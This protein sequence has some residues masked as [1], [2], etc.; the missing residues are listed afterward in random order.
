MNSM[1]LL[2]AGEHVLFLQGLA[3]LLQD[4]TGAHVHVL[5][6]SEHLDDAVRETQPDVVVAET[7][8]VPAVGGVLARLPL[9][10][11]LRLLIIAPGEPEQ[12]LAALRAGA[13][14]FVVRDATADQLLVCLDAVL[15]GEWG[16]P[17]SLLGPLVQEYLMLVHADHRPPLLELSERERQILR[18]LAQG[19]SAQ[20]IGQALYLSEST[21]RADVRTLARKFGVANRMQVVTE[22]LRRGLVAP[23]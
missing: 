21:I 8:N 23:D 16:L 20:R 6:L 3:K 5:T 4:H 1:R 15:R 11:G 13:R 9:S 14:G 2:L 10:D 22:A 12:F 17:R 18:L 19:M 7:S